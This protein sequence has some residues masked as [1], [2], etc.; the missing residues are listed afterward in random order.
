MKRRSYRTKIE[1]AKL[2]KEIS[3]RLN[4]MDKKKKPREESEEL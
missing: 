3:D 2:L 1:S 4:K